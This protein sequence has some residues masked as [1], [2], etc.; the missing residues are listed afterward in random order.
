MPTNNISFQVHNMIDD[1]VQANT[2]GTDFPIENNITIYSLIRQVTSR[3]TQNIPEPNT[4]QLHSNIILTVELD[5]I[6]ETNQENVVSRQ[7]DLS[8]YCKF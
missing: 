6:D 1:I 3:L 7:R 2:F 8:N 4:I 5:L